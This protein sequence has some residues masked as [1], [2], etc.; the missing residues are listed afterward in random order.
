MKKNIL[1]YGERSSGKTTIAT[2]LIKELMITKPCYKVIIIDGY[3]NIDMSDYNELENTIF[4]LDN[5]DYLLKEWNKKILEMLDNN[6]CICI[7]ILQYPKELKMER[8]LKF[9]TLIDS[10]KL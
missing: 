6:A 7:L 10:K 1:I 2:N 4:I 5:F 8:L 3:S 9:D